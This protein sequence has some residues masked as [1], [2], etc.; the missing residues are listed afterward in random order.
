M[1]R[2]S[3]SRRVAN[4]FEIDFF[5]VGEN[6][7]GDAIALRYERYGDSAVHV[8]DGGF[9]DDGSHVL[10]H[11]CNYYGSKDVSYV[12]LTHPDSDHAEGLRTVLEECTVP[13]EGGLWMLRPWLYTE[14]LLDH[15]AR[16]TTVT[17]LETAL[18]KAYPNVAALEEIA[19]RREIPIHAPFQG[20]EIGAFTVL[21]PSKSRYLQ[22]IVDSDRTPQKAARAHSMGLLETHRP[23]LAK[24][25][26]YAKA[27]WGVEVFSPEPTSAENEMSVVQ[28]ASLC[29]EKILLTGDAGRDGLTEAADFAPDIGLQLPG[30]DRFDVPHHG[31]RRNVS[32]TVLD[33]WLGPRLPHQRAQGK[34]SFWAFISANPKDDAHPRRAVVRG[35]IHR[36]ANV[37][38]TTSWRGGYLRTSKNAPSRPG[39]VPAEQLAYPEDQEEE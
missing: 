17:A 9:Q 34:G 27:A 38:Q 3:G 26:H 20:E 14:E 32:T 16:F 37:V 18:R 4:Y 33:Q 31:S 28:Y 36:G 8:I 35:L 25:V 11:L 19:L 10:T 12:V 23:L 21:A 7:S 29:D 5:R 6:R 2:R 1:T 39:A 30:I 15:F 24:V 22:L 13:H